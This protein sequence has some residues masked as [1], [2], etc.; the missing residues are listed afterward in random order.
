[1]QFLCTDGGKN[2][3]PRFSLPSIWFFSSFSFRM[4]SSTSIWNKKKTF[5]PFFF[6]PS[7]P[8]VINGTERGNPSRL[9][10]HKELYEFFLLLP[11]SLRFISPAT[12][13]LDFMGEF[14]K[15]WHFKAVVKFWNYTLSWWN[16]LHFLFNTSSTN[17]RVFFYWI[18]IKGLSN[19]SAIYLW[20]KSGTNS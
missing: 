17:S 8:W 19:A 12:F 11:S 2:L 7:F 15:T 6:L 4:V 1:M 16:N 10:I 13:T 18:F 14:L 3:M 20:K 5:S 9:K